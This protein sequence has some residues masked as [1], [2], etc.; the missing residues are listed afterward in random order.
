[1]PAKCPYGPEEPD[2][3]ER[4][5]LVLEKQGL[6]EKRVLEGHLVKRPQDK[7]AWARN[8]NTL[9]S[10]AGLGSLESLTETPSRACNVPAMCPV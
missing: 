6:V 4:R 1:M 9:M 3:G 8:T 5:G 2:D 7:D 10:L